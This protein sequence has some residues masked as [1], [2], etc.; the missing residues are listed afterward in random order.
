MNWINEFSVLPRN[1]FLMFI[2]S[3]PVPG[4]FPGCAPKARFAPACVI[5]QDRFID[6]APVDLVIITGGSVLKAGLMAMAF[7]P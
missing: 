1:I 6:K 2:V 5:D 4:S 7:L 3:V